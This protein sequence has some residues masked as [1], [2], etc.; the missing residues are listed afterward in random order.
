MDTFHELHPSRRKLQRYHQQMVDQGTVAQYHGDYDEPEH[1]EEPPSSRVTQNNCSRVWESVKTWLPSASSLFN[2][3]VEV[4]TEECEGRS[5]QEALFYRS[6][7]K[8]KLKN[9]M[10]GQ[11]MHGILI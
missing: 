6:C 5:I 8:M 9:I 2:T 3:I 1:Q 11:C 4:D 10:L 7:S